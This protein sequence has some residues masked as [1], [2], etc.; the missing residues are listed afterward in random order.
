MQSL[1]HDTSLM[2]LHAIM[3]DGDDGCRRLRARDW[4][5]A[6]LSPPLPPPL[7]QQTGVACRL[8]L[9]WLSPLLT[10]TLLLLSRAVLGNLCGCSLVRGRPCVGRQAFARLHIIFG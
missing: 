2:Q 9:G 10:F 8:P 6:S 1:D 5:S 3:G 4:C 7:G